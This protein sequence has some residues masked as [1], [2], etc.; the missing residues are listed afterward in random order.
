MSE[1]FKPVED[2]NHAQQT[3][4]TLGL[5]RVAE[6]AEGDKP[7][8]I[9]INA[10]N[11]PGNCGILSSGGDEQ[12]N[13]NCP[14]HHHD[15]NGNPG[16]DERGATSMKKRS[17]RPNTR[18]SPA[19][20]L[21]KQNAQLKKRS[22]TSDDTE[23]DIQIMMKDHLRQVTVLPCCDLSLFY[24]VKILTNLLVTVYLN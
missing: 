24:S 4:A 16:R 9:P 20:L 5:D 11:A 8:L 18:P 2:I 22:S 21:A 3:L 10:N 19:L 1:D 6:N 13:Q 14:P 17:K 23:S 15:P 7:A 12:Q